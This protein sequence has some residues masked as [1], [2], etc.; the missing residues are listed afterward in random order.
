ME[1]YLNSRGDNSGAALENI[2]QG[3]LSSQV[4]VEIPGINLLQISF[5]KGHFIS[6]PSTQRRHF[7]TFKIM[8]DCESNPSQNVMS[9]I[10]AEV[11]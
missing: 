8:K 1:S 7:K 2:N 4:P 10:L 3:I 6:T 5:L 9:S 11:E